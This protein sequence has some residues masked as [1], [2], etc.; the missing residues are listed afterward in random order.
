MRA[1][2]YEK[3]STL[4]ANDVLLIDGDRGVKTISPKTIHKQLL[5]E[6]TNAEYW[7]RV[8]EFC[9][10]S[11]NPACIRKQFYRGKQLGT[12]FTDVHKAAIRSGKF[13]DMFI[14]DYWTINGRLWAISDF[15]YWLKKGDTR[16]E[17]SHVLIIPNN[18]LYTHVMND[19]NTTE[20]GYAGSKMFSSGGLNQAYTMLSSDF[21]SSNLLTHRELFTNAVTN[22]RPSN[23]NWYDSN[24][25]LMNEFMVY[26]HSVFSPANDGSNILYNYTIDINQLAIFRLRPEL[27]NSQRSWYWLRDVVSAANFAVVHGGGHADYNGAS[28]AAGVRPVCGIIG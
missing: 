6:T 25:T 26:G 8:N 2:D 10:G 3:V 19:T 18:N 13:D 22:G 24:V 7:K 20:G 14:G 23:G 5:D 27:Q 11:P 17:T 28:G 16:C 4:E 21:G 1:K 12:S 15:N 9:N